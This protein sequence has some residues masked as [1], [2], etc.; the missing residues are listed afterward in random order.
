MNGSPA[1]VRK[2]R[3]ALLPVV[4]CLMVSRRVVGTSAGWVGAARA[5]AS[6]CRGNPIEAASAPVKAMNERRLIRVIERLSSCVVGTC[7]IVA[8]VPA[9]QPHKSFSRTAQTP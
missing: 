7:A 9:R 8:Q 4:D 1:A 6:I 5:G 2:V 3:Y